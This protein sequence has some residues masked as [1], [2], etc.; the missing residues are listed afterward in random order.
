MAAS[1]GATRSDSLKS[2]SM[3]EPSLGWSPQVGSD[4]LGPNTIDFLENDFRL[5]VANGQVL[6]HSSVTP[7]LDPVAHDVSEDVPAASGLG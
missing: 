3:D 7:R 6:R 1:K 2:F 5:L 4:Q